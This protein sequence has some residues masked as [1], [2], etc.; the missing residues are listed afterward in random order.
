MTAGH[1]FPRPGNRIVAI[2]YEVLIWDDVDSWGGEVDQVSTSVS[3]RLD[4]GGVA[5][6]RWE[7]REG[8]ES[9]TTRGWV[10]GDP[11]AETQLVD[12]TN[13]WTDI[14]GDT[15]Q[16]YNFALHDVGNG[17]EPWACRLQLGSGR[18]LAIALGELSER[19]I[20]YVPDCLIV[21]SSG[22]LASRYRP[23]VAWDSAWGAT[24]STGA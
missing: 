22:E 13:R 9:L 8:S 14:V 23:P 24:Y 2:V 20:T 16:R 10:A 17:P 19:R 12:V 5:R 3:V 7:L 4:G 15:L 6:F 11:V 1:E 21:T 18:G